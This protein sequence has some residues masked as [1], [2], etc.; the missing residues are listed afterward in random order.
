MPLPSTGLPQVSQQSQHK[1]ELVQV[2]R[3]YLFLIL[4]RIIVLLDLLVLDRFE[5]NQTHPMIDR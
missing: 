3:L 5:S 4:I 2:L 1:V